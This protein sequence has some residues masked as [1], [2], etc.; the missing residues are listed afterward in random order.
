MSARRYDLRPDRRRVRATLAPL[1]GLAIVLAF[2][3]AHTRGAVALAQV[4]LARVNEHIAARQGA[5]DAQARARREAGRDTASDD[6]SATLTFLARVEGAW[7]DNLALLRV[8]LD[9]YRRRAALQLEGGSPDELL[10]FVARLQ[11]RF[12]STA[13]IMLERHAAAPR[14]GRWPLLANVSIEWP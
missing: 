1:A 12:G 11:T 10:D 2:G 14:T 9:P 6:L 4:E 3:I 5:L 7:R 13:T 8:D